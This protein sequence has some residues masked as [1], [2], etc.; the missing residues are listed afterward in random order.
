[1][2]PIVW[3]AGLKPDGQ[4]KLNPAVQQVGI[5]LEQNGK[6]PLEELLLEEAPPEEEEELEEEDDDEL[7]EEE[8]DEALQP[9]L[10]T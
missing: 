7:L 4:V 8:D 9:E 1:M 5:P 10:Q 6:H 3:H 2:F